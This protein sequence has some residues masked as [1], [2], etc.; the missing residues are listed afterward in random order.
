[1]EPRVAAT[2]PVIATRPAV[3]V[4]VRRSGFAQRHVA[5]AFLAVVL[6]ADVGAILFARAKFLAV[7]GSAPNPAV[8]GL[9]VLTASYGVVG[10]I[11]ASRRPD[12]RIGWVFLTIGLSLSVEALA[13]A[14]SGLDTVAAPGSLP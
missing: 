5:T 1:M 14:Y 3:P 8:L 9:L 11:V 10:W 12:N 4:R 2:A 6:L 7:D 13:T